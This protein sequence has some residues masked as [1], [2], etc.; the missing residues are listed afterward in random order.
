MKKDAA[1]KVSV[2][3]PVLNGMPYF[4]KALD[5]VRYQEMKDIEIIVVDAGS[6]D[7]TVAYVEECMHLD[8]RIKLLVSERK[9]HGVQCN[10]GMREAEGKY[11]AFCESDDYVD[12]HMLADLYET[13]EQNDYPDCVKSN[14]ILFIDRGVEEFSI[15][16]DVLS[17]KK[18][19]LYNKVISI[20]DFAGLIWRDI[21]MV[22]GIYLNIF[23]RESEIRL[24]ETPGASFQ[25][26]GFV[27]QVNL[28]AKRQVFVRKA[29]YHYR[30]DNNGSSVYKKER[31]RFAM[32]ECEY[33]LKWIRTKKNVDHNHGLLAISRLLNMFALLYSEDIYKY[34]SISFD[35]ELEGFQK[36]VLSF[37]KEYSLTERVALEGNTFVWLFLRDIEQFK[38]LSLVRGEKEIWEIATFKD[39]ITSCNSVVIVTAGD[40]GTGLYALLVR[41]N[42]DGKVIFCDNDKD[43]QG[44]E[45]MG[46]P[47]LSVEKAVEDYSNALYLV[48]PLV[49]ADL[50]E[51]LKSNGIKSDKIV[52]APFITA[53]TSME[54]DFNQIGAS[55]QEASV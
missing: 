49:Y 13:A 2:V 37:L 52:C 8:D 19:A 26:I 36:K 33:A 41:N 47:V 35:E 18:K 29:Y 45:V 14:L 16:Y 28:L 55:S 54:I 7:G 32:Q 22:Y 40:V 42:W 46:V 3:M 23:L 5:S 53:H 10:M 4:K 30:K 50:T 43:K 39:L 34:K 44:T 24:N 51:Q 27:Q 6:T 1:K 11:V 48:N 17:N 12:A 38:L 9:S 15:I 31:S 21:N 25:D 20:D